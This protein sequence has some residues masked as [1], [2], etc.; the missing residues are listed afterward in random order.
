MHSDYLSLVIQLVFW[1]NGDRLHNRTEDII[2]NSWNPCPPLGFIP[3]RRRRSQSEPERGHTSRLWPFSQITAGV[4]VL[5]G[6]HSGHLS[7]TVEFN[8][9]EGRMHLISVYSLFNFY[10]ARS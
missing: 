9:P 6:G 3:S 1:K 2:R 4:L 8:T 10:L 5:N 7:D